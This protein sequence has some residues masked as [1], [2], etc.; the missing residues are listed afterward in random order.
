MSKKTKTVLLRVLRALGATVIASVAAFLAG[1]DVAEIVPGGYQFLVTGI[2][3]P[4]LLGL[5]KYLRY[6]GD[7]GEARPNAEGPV[8]D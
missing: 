3:V 1:P 8:T 2:T 7:P 4:L 6:G 5:E